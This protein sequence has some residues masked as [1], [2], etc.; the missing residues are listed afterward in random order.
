M[1]FITFTLL[2]FFKFI[3]QNFNFKRLLND[4]YIAKI[5]SSFIQAS[6]QSGLIMFFYLGLLFSRRFLPFSFLPST[7]IL[8]SNYFPTPSKTWDSQR[9]SAYTYEDYLAEK[10]RVEEQKA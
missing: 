3:G 5:P 7:I 6:A 9:E 1:K 8:M 4:E 2:L 10:K